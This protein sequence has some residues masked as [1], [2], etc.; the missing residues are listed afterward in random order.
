[1]AT[2]EERPFASQGAEIRCPKCDMSAADVQRPDVGVLEFRCDACGHKW[3]L[4]DRS[5]QE[6]SER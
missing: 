1:M 5:P 2:K 6:G 4:Y 3:W